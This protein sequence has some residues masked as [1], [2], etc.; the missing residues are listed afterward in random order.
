V[1]FALGTVTPCCL[2]LGASGGNFSLYSILDPNANF[3]V[4]KQNGVVISH[5]LIWLSED[6][7][8]LVIDSIDPVQDLAGHLI[9]ENLL[10]FL[11]NDIAKE[12]LK[13]NPEIEQVNMS[14]GGNTIRALPEEPLIVECTPVALLD[15]GSPEYYKI[16]APS[17]ESVCVQFQ[18]GKLSPV[19]D[20]EMPPNFEKRESGDDL[21]VRIFEGLHLA[22]LEFEDVFG[23]GME[24]ISH[25]TGWLGPTAPQ[26]PKNGRKYSLNS[27]IHGTTYERQM[28]MM[29]QAHMG[30]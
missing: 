1:P 12:I 3:L 2:N 30:I 28:A 5:A 21:L 23:C 17:S 9:E 29:E 4:V 25:N 19:P 11:F 13:A 6:G 14:I 18:D 27:S 7:K 26:K 15:C 16:S 8:T 10:V 20:S 22:S 24:S